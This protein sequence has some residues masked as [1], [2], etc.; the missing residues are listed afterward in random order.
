VIAQALPKTQELLDK[1]NSFFSKKRRLGTFDAR[2]LKRE[3]EK[4]KGK[5]EYAHYYDILGQISSLEND[6]ANT[7]SFYENA[8]KLDPNNYATKYNYIASLR[9]CGLLFQSYEYTKQLLASYPNETNLLG[10]LIENSYFLCCFRETLQLLNKLERKTD[11]YAYETLLLAISIFENAQLSDTESNNLCQL[12]YSVLDEQNL[13]LT[14][15]EIEIIDNCVLYT[16]YVDKSIEEIF[17]INWELAN[18]FAEKVDDMR[19]D[20]L[21]FEYSSVDILEEKEKYERFV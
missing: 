16:I 14:G 4:L 7:I 15:L 3:A 2:L 17:E 12:A 1:V 19:S 11:F 8:I 10:V 9:N 13:C 18:I 6:R 21:M 5:I 20:V